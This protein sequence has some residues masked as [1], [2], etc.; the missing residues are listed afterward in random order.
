[1]S[2]RVEK[3]Q[4]KLEISI[5]KLSKQLPNFQ[6]EVNNL[7]FASDEKVAILGPSGSGKSTL[8]RSVLGLDAGASGQIDISDT[9]K[10]SGKNLKTKLAYVGQDLGLVET[11]TAVENTLQ[12]ALHKY[13][14]PKIG[15]SSYQQ[16]DQ[17]I[18]L[19]LLAALEITEPKA[20]VS[21]MSGGQKQRVAIAR[22]LAQ[23]PSMLLADEPLSSLDPA[24]S[25][26]VLQIL[27]DPSRKVGLV[28]ALHQPELALKYFDRVVGLKSGAVVFD[29]KATEVSKGDLAAL[30]ANEAN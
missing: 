29:R 19:Q 3:G 27:T 28:A 17:D 1:M 16:A 8:L 10:R 26:K 7:K 13:R 11:L 22:A 18:A 24:T 6:L 30:Y 14:L 20:L 25:L 23:L 4:G 5:L 12:G 21:Q 2:N 15:F 9:A